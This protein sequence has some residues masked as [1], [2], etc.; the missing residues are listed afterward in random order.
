MGTMTRQEYLKYIKQGKGGKGRSRCNSTT[1]TSS[2]YGTK[3]FHSKLE[4]QYCE[5]LDWQLEAGEI[6][7]YYIQVKVP[8]YCNEAFICNYYIDFLVVGKHQEKI[9]VEVKGYEFEVWRLKWKLFEAQVH[10]LHK[11]VKEL[12]GETMPELKI[13]KK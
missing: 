6:E 3:T 10:E 5:Q 7:T 12:E 8:L 9:L 2:L 13:V 4:A 11:H 1:Y